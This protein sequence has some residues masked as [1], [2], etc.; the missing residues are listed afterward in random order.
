M[1]RC[2]TC[3]EL[4]FLTDFYKFKESPDGYR[5]R[6]KPC[7]IKVVVNTRDRDKK[8]ARD[9]VYAA[10]RRITN[11][12]KVREIEKRYEAKRKSRVGVIIV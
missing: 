7:W 6:C 1:K 2:S 3:N 10:N 4:K 8:R 5:K 11:Y 12:A 9:K